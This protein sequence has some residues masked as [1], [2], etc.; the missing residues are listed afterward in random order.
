[1]PLER[2][3]EFKIKLQSGMAHIAKAPYE[4]WPVELAELQVQL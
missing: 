4:M 3:I 1:M 2:D